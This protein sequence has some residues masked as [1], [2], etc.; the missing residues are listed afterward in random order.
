MRLLV[1]CVCVCA[2]AFPLQASM[3]PTLAAECFNVVA[4]F[5]CTLNQASDVA[6]FLRRCFPDQENDALAEH[7]CK[8]YS[9]ECFLSTFSRSPLLL[10]LFFVASHIERIHTFMGG[11]ENLV[12]ELVEESGWNEAQLFLE[13]IAKLGKFLTPELQRVLCSSCDRLTFP[14]IVTRFPPSLGTRRLAGAAL[15]S[16][17][18][19][20]VI[21]ES[22]R[23]TA[24]RVERVEAVD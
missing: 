17:N 10:R 18:Q 2:P 1:W 23:V 5:T 19:K 21:S 20:A 14:L 9:L 15:H 8:R 16:G 22:S 7:E 6:L 12:D 4:T 3:I 11:F 24:V 13:V